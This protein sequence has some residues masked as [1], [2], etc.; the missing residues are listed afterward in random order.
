MSSSKPTDDSDH[1]PAEAFKWPPR[2]GAAAGKSADDRSPLARHDRV[3]SPGAQRTLTPGMWREFARFSNQA[4]G[5]L[6]S[7][8]LLAAG[9][10]YL[11][12][13]V[14]ANKEP[15]EENSQHPKT[16]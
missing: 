8:V 15:K 12:S 14:A 5:I 6:G 11:A 10:A 13:G 16:D 3:I 4:W 7:S 9:V 1:L 2:K